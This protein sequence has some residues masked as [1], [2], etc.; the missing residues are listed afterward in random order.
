MQD[1]TRNWMLDEGNKAWSAIGS[2]DLLS[3]I[4]NTELRLAYNYSNYRGTYGFQL[5]AG[6]TLATP[7]PLPD[8][9]SSESRASVDV[10]YFITR[11]VAVGLVYW[12]DSYDVSDFTLSPDVVS[13]VAQPAVEEGQSATVNALLLNYFYRPFKAHTAWLRLTYAF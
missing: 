1:P 13:G 3:G 8:I 9:T 4:E 5:P 6:T 2:L 11:R 7:V 10:R 12:Y